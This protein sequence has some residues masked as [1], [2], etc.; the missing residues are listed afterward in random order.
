MAGTKLI[1]ILSCD[2]TLKGRVI[3][4][5]TVKTEWLFKPQSGYLNCRGE[6][7]NIVPE[8]HCCL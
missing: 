5:I 1:N 8:P 3:T 2:I 4:Y 7:E 6:D